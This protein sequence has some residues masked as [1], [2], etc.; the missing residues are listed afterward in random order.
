MAVTLTG[1]HQYAKQQATAEFRR[2]VE[3]HT[4]HGVYYFATEPT[5]WSGNFYEARLL[6]IGGLTAEVGAP[7][8]GISALTRIAVTYANADGWFSRQGPDFLRDQRLILREVFLDVESDAARTWEFR[9]TDG[10]MINP[11]QYRVNGED[12]WARIRRL[13]VPTDQLLISQATFPTIR[14]GAAA[15]GKPIPFVYGRTLCP[16]QLVDDTVDDTK[17]IACIGCA[18]I[19]GDVGSYFVQ[20]VFNEGLS[21]VESA[22]LEYGIANDVPVTFVRIRSI[23]YAGNEPTP[24]YA[25]LIAPTGAA[26]RPDVVLLDLLTHP[27]AGAGLSGGLVNSDSLV[28]AKNFYEENSI[29]FDAVLN[30]QRPLESWLGDWTRDSLT[31]V[32][33]RDQFV[34]VPQESRAP[35]GSFTPSNILRGTLG[36]DDIALRSENSRRTVFFQDRTKDLEP[37]SVVSYVAGSGSLVTHTSPFL[38]TPSAAFRVARFWSKQA[39]AGQRVYGLT[40]TIRSIELEE[41]DLVTLTHSQVGLAG[42]LGEVVRV[43]RR[44]EEISYRIRTTSIGIFAA[45]TLEVPTDPPAA[46]RNYQFVGFHPSDSSYLLRSGVNS[47]ITVTFS[48]LVSSGPTR[49]QPRFRRAGEDVVSSLNA[50]NNSEATVTH[51]GR[52]TMSADPLDL[53]VELLGWDVRV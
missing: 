13:N 42:A 47:Y 18:T 40:S 17:W 1:S 11:E 44:G 43:E 6:S 37:I 2:L 23:I 38:G 41:N 29:G 28:T 46:R 31:R 35:V 53:N 32:S 30:V 49:A 19:P 16:L 15:I 3:Q 8:A 51:T 26:G 27:Y 33:L 50:V 7:E 12:L 52:T 45:N 48:H 21:V 24:H 10:H 4:Q 5:S 14:D 25:E 9:V 39:A 20:E 22:G 36:F 34:L